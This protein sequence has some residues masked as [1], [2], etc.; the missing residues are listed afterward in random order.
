LS[1]QNRFI[2]SV[3]LMMA[4]FSC[5]TLYFFPAKQ[6]QASEASLSNKA[7]SIAQTLSVNAAAGVEFED[8]ASVVQS[9]ESVKSDSDVRY[10]V[11]WTNE[12]REFAA[13]AMDSA[14]REHVDTG[15]ACSTCH[16]SEDMKVSIKPATVSDF[17]SRWEDGYLQVVGPI[18]NHSGTRLGSIQVGVST[19]RIEGEFSNSVVTTVIFCVALTLVALV[20]IYFLGRQIAAPIAGLAAAAEQMAKEDMTT[21]AE[22]VNLIAGGDL[23]R[24]ISVAQ[25]HIAADTGGEVGR[26]ASAFNLMQ[27]K[28]AEIAEAFTSMSGGLRD[29][30]VHVQQ[31]ADGVAGGSEA[32]ATASGAAVQNSEATVSAVETITATMHEMNANIQNVARSAQSQASSTTQ[33][34][35]SI[36]SLLS[37][38]QTVAKAAEQL[39]D[40]AKH[41]DESVRG[42]HEAMNTAADGMSEI[43][44]VSGTSSRFVESLGTTAEDIGKIVGVIEDIAEQTN[45]LAL[46]AAI[47]AARAGEHGLGFAVVAEEVRKLAERSAKSTGE[48]AD[49]I[50][51][52]Q[53]H[54]GEAVRNMAR[55]TAIVEQGMKKTEDLSDSLQKIDSAVSEV[56]KCSLDI[57][58]ATAEQSAGAQ[59]IEQSTARLA[60]LTQEISAATEEQSTGTE[61]VVQGVERMK[62]MVQQNADSASELASSAEE[63]SRQSGLM[64]Q[65]VARFH[66][67]DGGGGSS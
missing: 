39:V 56:A 49:L 19:E 55:T 13:Y 15:E 16:S 43:R 44:E 5:F 64:R 3:G 63:L 6:R 28:L 4:L 47:E 22:E 24:H 32:V 2:V 25:R 52:I 21:F 61:Q 18:Q 66:L 8:R 10:V 36:E 26:M 11:V 29:I 9:F 1:I 60:E 17:Q 59:Q 7:Q 14:R 38:V 23:T 35:A 33:T 34:L 50:R 48:I 67:G 45:L 58:N 57:G 51:N 53:A 20:V 31:A 42:G 12:G 46:N 41:A 40:I 65:W 27:A 54:V 62:G 30:V 37:S